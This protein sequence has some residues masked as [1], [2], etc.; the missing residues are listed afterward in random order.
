MNAVMTLEEL[1][2]RNPLPEGFATLTVLVCG[3]AFFGMLLLFWLV[4]WLR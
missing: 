1:M 4:G 2:D 3:F